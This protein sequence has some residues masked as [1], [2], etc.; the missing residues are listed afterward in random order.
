MPMGYISNRTNVNGPVALR[1]P[2]EPLGS[3]LECND[4][5]DPRMRSAVKAGPMRAA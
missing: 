5:H 1:H 4:P 2:A 3:F